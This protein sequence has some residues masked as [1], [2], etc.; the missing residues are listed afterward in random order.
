VDEAHYGGRP[1]T[2][3]IRAPA[4]GQP[5][6]VWVIAPSCSAA[7]RQVIKTAALPASG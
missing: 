3:I 2:V 4:G 1:A 6:H 7:N 5:G